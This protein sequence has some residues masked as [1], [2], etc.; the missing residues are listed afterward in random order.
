[1]SNYLRIILIS[2]TYMRDIITPVLNKYSIFVSI[3]V[4]QNGIVI[5]IP[6]I[7]KNFIYEN[8]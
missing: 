2:T 6:I 8:Q 4:I 3:L 7:N 1:M 5:S